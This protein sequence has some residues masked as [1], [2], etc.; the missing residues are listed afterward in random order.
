MTISKVFYNTAL[1][2]SINPY[3]QAYFY[4]RDLIASQN[5]KVYTLSGHFIQQFPPVRFAMDI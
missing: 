4:C 1:P 5:V 2:K 3:E